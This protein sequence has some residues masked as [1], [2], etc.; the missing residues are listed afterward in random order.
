MLT[1]CIAVQAAVRHRAGSPAFWFTSGHQERS[2]V[3]SFVRRKLHLLTA[4]LLAGPIGIAVTTAAAHADVNF[5][6]G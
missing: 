2:P 3:V 5:P 6:T 4:A 1:Y